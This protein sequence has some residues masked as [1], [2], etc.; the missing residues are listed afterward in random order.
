MF[1]QWFLSPRRPMPVG[2]HTLADLWHSLP[3]RCGNLVLKPKNI[4]AWVANSVARMESRHGQAGRERNCSDCFGPKS[5]TRRRRYTSQHRGRETHG[6]SH[7]GS[8]NLRT[9]LNLDALLLELHALLREEP[10]IGSPRF[11]FP[12]GFRSQS[13][14][15]N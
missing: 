8:G 7:R 1:G 3:V 10:Y 15:Q 11:D 12:I 13:R 2:K 5:P 4:N 9:R 14:K 6:R